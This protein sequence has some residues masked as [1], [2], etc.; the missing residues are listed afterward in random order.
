MTSMRE[1]T[2]V[3]AAR[4]CRKF[5]HIS[6]D[7][8]FELLKEITLNASLY[9][10]LFDHEAFAYLRD[11]HCSYGAVFTFYLFYA[12]TDNRFTMADV[13]TRFR[14]EFAANAHWLKFGYHSK[15]E[16]TRSADLTDEE[17]I[18]NVR[19][20][21]EAIVRF[22]GEEA[23]DK[24][25]RFGFFSVNPSALKKLRAQ[26]LILGSLTA[27]DDRADNNGLTGDPLRI[28]QTRDRHYDPSADFHYFR[29]ETRMD[30]LNTA[31][32]ITGKLEELYQDPNNNEAFILFAHSI[33]EEPITAAVKW[34]HHKQD[35]RFD[36]PVSFI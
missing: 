5:M 34:A 22:A 23:I 19:E 13:T 32:K 12:R 6:F 8:T 24:V 27:D 30:T 7:D 31:D 3:N 33:I 9:D 4:K 36:Y 28:V 26:N 29:S 14:D 15:Y 35:I 2:G 20:M 10:S 25:V 18:A 21:H 1:G 11:L 17:L 16:T